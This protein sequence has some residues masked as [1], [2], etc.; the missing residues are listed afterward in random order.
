MMFLLID[1]GIL[2]EPFWGKIF[3]RWLRTHSSQGEGFLILFDMVDSSSPLQVLERGKQIAGELL[4][5]GINALPLQGYG[6]GLLDA[7]PDGKVIVRK[8]EWLEQLMMQGALP[9]LIPLLRGEKGPVCV[10]MDG[11][12][13]GLV[14]YWER[15]ETLTLV[16]LRGAMESAQTL[17][18]EGILRKFEGRGLRTLTEVIS[19]LSLR[20][21]K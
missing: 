12:L 2:Q 3:S 14:R 21:R 7:L 4:T 19:G 15:T 13:D 6:R 8:A 18:F 9:V 16:H 5:E 11:V 17:P 10:S 1:E 20:V